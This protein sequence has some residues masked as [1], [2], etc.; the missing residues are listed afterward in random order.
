MVA[1]KTVRESN[2]ALKATASPGF[3]AVF[4][5]GT[6]GIGLSTFKELI[7]NLTASKIYVVGRSKTRFTDQLAE[8]GSLNPGASIEFVEAELSLLKDVDS[9]CD[10]VKSK[11]RKLDLLYMSP[12]YLAFGGPDCKHSLRLDLIY[13]CA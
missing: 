3:V 7:K 5:G 1:I 4:A 2:A 12:G 13:Y 11:E 8:L 10:V 9:V 6:N